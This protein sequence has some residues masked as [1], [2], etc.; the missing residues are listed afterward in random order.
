RIGIEAPVATAVLHAEQWLV[1]PVE[2]AVLW[3]SLRIPV[4]HFER[5]AAIPGGAHD[6][7]RPFWVNFL[8][9]LARNDLFKAC[10]EPTPPNHYTYPKAHT[11]V[12]PTFVSFYGSSRGCL[13][14]TAYDYSTRSGAFQLP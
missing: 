14:W 1:M 10:H 8:Y 12:T 13:S 3:P 4:D 7:D 5:V 6:L 2:H 11:S 9:F